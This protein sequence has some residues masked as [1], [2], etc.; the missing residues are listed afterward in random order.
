MENLA[1]DPVNDPVM[2][3]DDVPVRAYRLQITGNSPHVRVA[4]QI[5]DGAENGCGKT[6]G[7]AG[8][9]P[10]QISMGCFEIQIGQA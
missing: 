2:A 1:I 10:F 6:P 7:G 5:L 9:L 3:A 4:L 8:I